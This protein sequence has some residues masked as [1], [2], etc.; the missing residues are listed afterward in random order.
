MLREFQAEIAYLK[1]QLEAAD[2]GS[3]AAGIAADS[4]AQS[5]EQQELK[6]APEEVA[7]MRK[8]LEEELRAEWSSSGAELSETA[9]SGLQE[10]V[11]A[12]LA[13]QEQKVQAERA[14]VAREA[15]K[16]EHSLREQSAQV[17][18]AA[19]EREQVQARK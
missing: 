7:R 11:E 14:R 12:Q 4:Q 17:Q 18:Q 10:E 19:A 2:P 9:L 16:L 5:P 6:L 1:T 8:Q 13:N 15:A 3:V